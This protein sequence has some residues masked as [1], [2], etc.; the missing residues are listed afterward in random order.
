MLWHPF[1][2][3]VKVNHRR[4]YPCILAKVCAVAMAIGLLKIKA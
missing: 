1:F 3:R 2:A 4:V